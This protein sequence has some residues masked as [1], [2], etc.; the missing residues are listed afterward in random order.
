MLYCGYR[1]TEPNHQETTSQHIYNLNNVNT[2]I[3]R[4]V[5]IFSRFG[6]GIQKPGPW[7]SCQKY[8]MQ[9]EW[10]SSYF[11]SPPAHKLRAMKQHRIEPEK[12]IT[13]SWRRQEE[14]EIKQIVE[15]RQKCLWFNRKCRD[16]VHYR[17]HEIKEKQDLK[18]IGEIGVQPVF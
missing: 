9:T 3:Q 14:N 6:E 10:Y 17:A 4:A 18:R 12:Q 11:H 2:Q 15:S 13:Q 5:N 8:N 1:V 7:S 16:D